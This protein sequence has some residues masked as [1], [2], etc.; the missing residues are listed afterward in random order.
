MSRL[1]RRVAREPHA[2]VHPAH[3]HQYGQSTGDQNN[4]CD[5]R[6]KKDCKLAVVWRSHSGNS[7]GE[8][9]RQLA[10]F[11]NDCVRRTFQIRGINSDAGLAIDYR[12]T[13]RN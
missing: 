6:H 1:E 12:L 7:A 4:G 10:N 5:I 8:I 2:V 3:Y 11:T 9:D 13:N